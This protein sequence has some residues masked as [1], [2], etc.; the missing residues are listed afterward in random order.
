MMQ[1]PLYYCQ[2]GF[3]LFLLIS[4]ILL[5][6]AGARA[7][8]VSPYKYENGNFRV[9][10]PDEQRSAQFRS[11]Y[12]SN[13][14]R[15]NTPETKT[16]NEPAETKT[17]S[18]AEYQA[19]KKQRIAEKATSDSLA[20]LAKEKKEMELYRY[21]QSLDFNVLKGRLDSLIS[22]CEYELV[23][24]ITL[25]YHEPLRNEIY[26]NHLDVF[27][28]RIKARIMS[29][30]Y[31]GRIDSAWVS[32]KWLMANCDRNNNTER[33][34]Y[35]EGIFWQTLIMLETG[36]YDSVVN[37]IDAYITAKP[38]NDKYASYMAPYYSAK[39]RALLYQGRPKEAMQI[40][41]EYLANANHDY[42]Y[43]YIVD[44]PYLNETQG[45]L[46]EKMGRKDSALVHYRKACLVPGGEYGHPE[47]TWLL[48]IPSNHTVLSMPVRIAF[49]KTA[50]LGG[51]DLNN[52][53]DTGFQLLNTAARMGLAEA[54]T[55][56]QGGTKTAPQKKEPTRA[57][58]KN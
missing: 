32:T 39:A 56:L 49:L 22:A 29:Q 28:K 48:K 10:T 19:R 6:A 53:N 17:L 45:L 54:Y 13:A 41:D 21:M 38:A 30:F 8:Y 33:L 4:G 3:M 52:P 27:R 7:Q 15:P 51:Y 46:F 2:P 5:T 20:R 16:G 47:K 1:R 42:F 25:L 36:M 44:N 18:Y 24:S 11:N 14:V 57:K 26:Y 9:M 31:L 40:L 23:D 37:R 58:K 34:E 43:K 55:L 12:N 35:E 50:K